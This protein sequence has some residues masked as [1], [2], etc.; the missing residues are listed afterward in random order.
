MKKIIIKLFLIVGLG[1]FSTGCSD[2]LDSDYLFDERMNI[3]DVFSNR[4]YTDKWLA[5]TYSYLAN[6]YLQ[7]VCSKKSMPYNFA[8]DM[9]FGD[10]SDGYKTWKSGNYNENGVFGESMGIWE[11]AYKGIKQATIFINNIDM[12]QAIGE[13]LRMDYKGQAIFLRAYFYWILLRTF[14]P[15]PLLPEEGIDYMEEYD[16]IAQPRNTYEECV[17]YIAGECVKAA[18]MLPMQR[19][20]SDMARSTRGAALALRAK[21]LLFGASPLY[22]GK[23]PVEVATALQDKHGRHLLPDTYDESKWAKAAAAAK[24]VMDL[25]WYSLYVEKAKTTGDIVYP[26]TVKPYKDGNF[27]EQDW[28]NGYRDIDPFESYRSVFNGR[29]QAHE[30]PELIFTRGR[31]QGGEYVNIMVLH[32]LPRVYG[33]GYGSHGMTLKQCDAYYMYDGT[34]CSGMNSM[35]A[36]KPGYTDPMRY[37]TEERPTEFVA[38]EELGNY[39]E[40]GIQ[41]ENV[42]KQYVQREPRF[43]ASVAYN[44]CTWN[45]TN[46]NKDQDEVSNVPVWYYRGTPNGYASTTYYPRSGIGIKKYVN[47]EDIGPHDYSAYNVGRLSQKVDPAI[48]YAEILLIYAEALNELTSGTSY[49]VSSW[50][51]TK[52]HSVSREVS[53]LKK[54]IQPIRIRAGIPDYSNEDYSNQ[55]KFRIKLKR[56][57]QI[58]LFAE[59]HRYFDLRR[60]MDAQYEEP[61]QVYGYNIYATEGQATLFHTPMAIAEF[62]TI[63]TTKMW[64]CPINHTEL[65]RNKELTQNP[66]WTNPE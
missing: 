39:P 59:G 50:D 28:P 16:K 58:E 19:G 53:E 66:G 12:N 62:P 56:E 2:Y 3:E 27:S 35:Y 51:G 10:M 43:Y 49:E 42:S 48:R 26:V 60:W 8:D 29:L 23:A 46:A 34:D 17:D 18:G 45:F 65:K 5:R 63:F 20:M 15:V 52:I 22:N 32:Q 57:R 37:N 40:L 24:D 25:N 38:M 61:L 6:N 9:Y 33:Y 44:G 36:G 7:D 1:A 13:E 11:N 54:G 14:G 64:F 55:D 4:E 31:N 30:N 21:V 47:P 41:G